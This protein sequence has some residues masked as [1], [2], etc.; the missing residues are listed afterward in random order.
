VI[1][2]VIGTEE[3]PQVRSRQVAALQRAGALVLPSNAHAAE[4]AVQLSTG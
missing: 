2:S 1:A 4:L 3:D